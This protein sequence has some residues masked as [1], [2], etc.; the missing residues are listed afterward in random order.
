MSENTTRRAR[1]T[2][3]ASILDGNAFRL[4]DAGVLNA[5]TR[6]LVERRQ[7][8]LGPAYRLFYRQPI[9]IVRG[10]GAHVWDADGNE[11]LDFYNNVPSLGHAHPAVVDA[12]QR[13]MSLLNVHTRYL[14]TTV[15]DYAEALL[16]TLP[17]EVDQVMFVCT[18]SEANDLALRVGREYTKGTAYIATSEAYHGNTALVSAHSPSLA[19]AET[20]DAALRIIDPPDTYREGSSDVAGARFLAAVRDA[21]DDIAR[22]GDGLAGMIVDTSFSSDGIYTGAQGMIAAALEFVQAQG[23]VVIADEVQPGF[24]RTGEAFWGFA[25]H[26]IVPDLVTMGKPMGNGF[27]VAAL[28]ARAEVL[29]PFA[30]GRP[31]FNT[32]GGNPVAMAAA[33]A[34]VDTI[35]QEGLQQHAL[36]VGRLLRDGLR[37][38]ADAH[39]AVG[40]I[41][42]AGLYT[43]LELV[44]DRDSKEPATS[45]A[46]ELL[47]HLRE[48]RVLTSV[49]GPTN[50]VL[51]LRPPL[52]VQEKD[53][54][55]LLDALDASLTALG[56]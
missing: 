22:S 16:R 33:R 56:A 28:A 36:D 4:R 25:R 43:G 44:R 40:D 1:E 52:A 3:N 39:P 30:T 26:G 32:F 11:Y 46:L 8:R 41:R 10:L 51:K 54:P 18:G 20:M 47:E 38:L 2:G 14:H 31:Y 55:W 27:P 45:L 21:V 37:A 15:I 53:L 19:G 6:E 17:T 42:G 12:V 50:S 29:A 5:R 49:C 48:R 24:A 7:R 23:G 34:V 13:Q 9:E 35:H